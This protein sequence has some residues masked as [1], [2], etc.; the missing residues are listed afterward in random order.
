MSGDAKKRLEQL[1]DQLYLRERDYRGEGNSAAVDLAELREQQDAVFCALGSLGDAERFRQS[2]RF[3]EDDLR[4]AQEAA[5]AANQELGERGLLIE[6]L[7]AS[8]MADH[9]RLEAEVQRLNARESEL[10]EAADKVRAMADQ[11]QAGWAA[12]VQQLTAAL[13]IAEHGLVTTHGLTAHDGQPDRSFVLDNDRELNVIEAALIRADVAPRTKI[14]SCKVGEVPDGS[15]PPGSDL[16]MRRAVNAAFREVTGKE[17]DFL[18]S[19]WCGELT[20]G[21]R[22]VVEN[23]GPA[24]SELKIAGMAHRRGRERL[25]HDAAE[26]RAL[27]GIDAPPP[28]PINETGREGERFCPCGW[29]RGYSAPEMHQEGCDELAKLLR[30][31]VTRG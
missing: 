31:A 6:S 30:E 17:A 16:P 20:E 1:R 12:Q 15:L 25:E 29:R 4:R 3:L 5:A 19:G 22:A 21:E 28:A 10:L 26:A 2:N 13:R 8:G 24:S 18:F 7:A 14:W 9:L 23:H 11:A 27:L